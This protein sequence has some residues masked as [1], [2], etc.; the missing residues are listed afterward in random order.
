MLLHVHVLTRGVYQIWTPESAE[1]TTREGSGLW[2][3]AALEVRRVRTLT[4]RVALRRATGEILAEAAP[5]GEH[6]E[7][8]R[9]IW[10]Q[11]AK[12]EG[13]FPWPLP[14]IFPH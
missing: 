1:E 3:R 5:P 11:Q 10:L 4:S 8:D 13:I 12:E 9:R 14:R 6:Y 7:V 2:R